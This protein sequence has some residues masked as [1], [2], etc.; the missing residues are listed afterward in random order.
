[1]TSEFQLA[2]LIKYVMIEYKVEPKKWKEI[3]LY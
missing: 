3:V 1:M 2:Q